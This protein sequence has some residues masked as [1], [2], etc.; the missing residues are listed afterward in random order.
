MYPSICVYIYIYYRYASSNKSSCGWWF[1]PLWKIWKSNGIIVPNTWKVIK[2]MFQT[3]NQSLYHQ[4][5]GSSINGG[6][7]TSSIFIGFSLLNYPAIGVPSLVETFTHRIHGA[8]IYANM[9]G[10]YWW[11]PWHTIYSSTM[12]PMG[13]VAPHDIPLAPGTSAPSC[14]TRWSD[15]SSKATTVPSRKGRTCRDGQ[16]STAPRGNREPWGSQVDIQNDPFMIL[17]SIFCIFI[18]IL[19]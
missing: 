12:D 5:A 4:N 1:Q 10:V 2:F 7:P 6:T 13:H 17:D 19:I 3:T 14:H 16:G 15:P 9:T 18:D 11:D 8:G